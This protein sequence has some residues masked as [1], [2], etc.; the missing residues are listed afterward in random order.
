LNS[1]NRS[2]KSGLTAIFAS[3]RGGFAYHVPR[4][5]E[6]AF[7]PDAAPEFQV[8]GAVVLLPWVQHS[9]HDDAVAGSELSGMGSL[10]QDDTRPREVRQPEERVRL[11]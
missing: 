5:G 3:D 11:G 6:A 2:L 1:E 7:G 9:G 8:E 4:C 10:C